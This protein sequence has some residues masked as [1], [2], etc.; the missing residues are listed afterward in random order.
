MKTKPELKMN[1]EISESQIDSEL[2][3]SELYA[4][5]TK[6][7]LAKLLLEWRQNNNVSVFFQKPY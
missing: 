3:E 6:L 2:P 4:E 5:E 1:Y 7:S